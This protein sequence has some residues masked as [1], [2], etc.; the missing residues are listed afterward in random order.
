MQNIQLISNQLQSRS[1]ILGSIASSICLVHCVATPFIFIAQGAELAHRHAHGH[2]A[3]SWWAVI[4]ILFLILSL[5]TVYWSAKKSSRPWVGYALWACWIFLC[6]VLLNEKLGLF[7]W[8]EELIY[9]PAI[10]LIVLHLYNRKYCKCKDE[11]CCA[12]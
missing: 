1:D 3:P 7:H 10:G 6:A 4:D 5:V 2:G 12:E 11:G 8:A 9:L